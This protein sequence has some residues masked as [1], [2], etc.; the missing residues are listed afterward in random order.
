M[1]KLIKT[2]TTFLLS[3]AWLFSGFPQIFNFP[4]GIQIVQATA[5]TPTIAG[6]GANDATVGTQ[7]WGTPDEITVT[8]GGDDGVYADTGVMAK[9]EVSEY[10]KATNFGFAIPDG[11]TILGIKVEIDRKE[12]N[13][14]A[15]GGVKDSEVKIVK[16]DATIGVTNKADT[17]NFWP[18]TEAV[19]TYGSVSDL[20]GESWTSANIN[21]ADFGVVLSAINTKVSGGGATE[22]AQV[23]FIRITITY[24]PASVTI[25]TIGTQTATVD[26]PSTGQYVG[27]AFTM[28]RSG[29]AANV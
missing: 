25:G 15:A 6:T 17:T 21:D 23:D 29:G 10:L 8:G 12:G 5:S 7:A 13:T 28:V 11:S 27:G 18:T 1:K 4:P 2:T 16:A 22:S 14:Q 26:I 24:G 19:A 20:W 9:S 3:I